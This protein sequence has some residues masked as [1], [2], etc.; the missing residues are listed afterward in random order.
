MHRWNL[1]TDP[2]ALC[3]GCCNTDNNRI[4]HSA[5]TLRRKYK[6]QQPGI[7]RQRIAQNG[8][9]ASTHKQHSSANTNMG[10]AL[11]VMVTQTL[12]DQ[13]R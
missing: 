4:R 6:G 3:G 11:S 9:E 7:E 10:T 13:Y 8:K 5:A 12:L 1:T 2:V